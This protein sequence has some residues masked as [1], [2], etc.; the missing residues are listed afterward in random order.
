MVVDAGAGQTFAH[1]QIF[2]VAIPAEAET[3]VI[4]PAMS[5]PATVAETPRKPAS[6][7]AQAGA[8]PAVTIEIPIVAAAAITTPCA[9]HQIL[10]RKHSVE[11]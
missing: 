7:P 5:D 3:A 11:S 10:H 2:A 1:E 6:T 9:Y 8:T 4:A